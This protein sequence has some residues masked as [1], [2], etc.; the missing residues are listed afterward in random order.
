MDGETLKSEFNILMTLNCEHLVKFV[1]ENTENFK[2]PDVL[3]IYLLKSTNVQ[4]TDETYQMILRI[5]ENNEILPKEK[6]TKYTEFLERAKIDSD[7]KN[8]DSISILLSNKQ[9]RECCIQ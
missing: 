3:C 7:L 8:F 1:L 2:Y 9:E 4:I 6:V 5:L